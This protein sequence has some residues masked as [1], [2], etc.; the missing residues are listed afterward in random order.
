MKKKGVGMACVLHPTGRKGG[1]DPSQALIQLK[2]DGTLLLMVGA[3]DHG[4]GALTILRQVAADAMDVPIETIYASNRSDDLIPL[5]S[6]SA[7]SRVTLV[8]PHAVVEA[9]EDL[10]DKIRAF[11][12]SQWG[13]S[14]E[15][16]EV[17]GG[18]AFVRDDPERTMTMKEIGASANLGHARILVGCG[19][20]Q[21]APVQSHDPETGAL[22]QESVMAFGCC[23]AEV[24]VDTETGVVE[25]TK[26]VQVWEVG[27]AIN[28]LMVK[29][30]INGGLQIGMGFAMLENIYPN[31]P[32][33]DHAVTQLA[34]YP[35]PTFMDYP[36]EL[37]HGIAE[38]PHPLGVEGAKGF[39]EGTA[40]GP[41]PAIISAI[42]DAIGVWIHEIPVSPEVVLR[43]LEAK[44]N[45]ETD[46][47][48]MAS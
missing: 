23:V 34:D 9:A 32:S 22:P 24:E 14:K 48:S 4:Q 7:A 25:V 8:D 35:I 17:A 40:S 26:L 12:A 28:P 1:G 43:A 29:Q 10:K 46:Y 42:H 3:V 27:K 13:V 39:S 18:K 37:I 33:P 19:A 20:W 31:Y 47:L 2:P 38:V 36:P 41:P 44:R 11:A 21:P 15:E 5:S 45:G 30:Q 6:G 16:V